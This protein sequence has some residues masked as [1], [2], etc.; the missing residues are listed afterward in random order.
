MVGR[1]TPETQRHHLDKGHRHLELHPLFPFKRG[2]FYG[3]LLRSLPFPDAR[4]GTPEDGKYLF[5][6][7][8]PAQDQT[9]VRSHVIFLEETLH[10]RKAWILQILG[11]SNH[12]IG[13]RM[14][15][16]V[17][18][19]QPFNGNA[20]H[21]VAI[22]V[23][24]LVDRLQ[25]IL[26]KAENRV[27]QSLAINL[28]P[29]LHVLRGEGI[30][31]NGIIE[32]STRVQLRPAITRDKP[33]ELVRNH[34]GG[35]LDAQFIDL[36]LQ[37][38]PLRSLLRSRQF[39]I[40]SRNTVQYFLFFLVI[41]RA[42]FVRS[43]EHHV[44]KIVRNAGIGAVFRTCLYH[45]RTQDFGLRMVFVQPNRQPIFQR[46]CRTDYFFFQ[47]FHSILETFSSN[48]MAKVASFF[49]SISINLNYS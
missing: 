26:E 43:L 21:I 22:H 2:Q 10:L 13:I 7:E 37:R 47:R 8:I 42:D 40:L 41:H 38:F 20:A 11:T 49:G 6:P 31:V 28:R 23:L 44:L 46:M 25:F 9:H 33:V 27:N 35:R 29:L 4:K 19:F 32:R 34:V 3:L 36:L 24:F 5:R 39:I 14:R 15:G 1:H 48:R 16:K 45:H 12:G 18:F 17:A 30:E